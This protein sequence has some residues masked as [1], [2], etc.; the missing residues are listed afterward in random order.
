MARRPGLRRGVGGRR[1]GCL[2]LSLPFWRPPAAVA[3]ASAAAPPPERGAQRV[4]VAGTWARV[5]PL[6]CASPL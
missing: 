5:M 6:V 4:A 1:R 3:A 2:G